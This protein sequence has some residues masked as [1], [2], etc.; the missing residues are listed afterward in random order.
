MRAP[1]PPRAALRGRLRPAQPPLARPWAPGRCGA[2]SAPARLTP[3][4]SRCA[5]RRLPGAERGAVGSPSGLRSPGSRLCPAARLRAAGKAGP[6]DTGSGHGD[7][8]RRRDGDGDSPRAGPDPSPPSRRVPRS[9]RTASSRR[10][11]PPSFPTASA[12]RLG[13]LRAFDPKQRPGPAEPARN[14][15]GREKQPGWG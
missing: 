2:V 1:P 7:S 14:P 8:H 11:T 13:L 12:V 15:R 4:A 3:Q 9:P 10:R 5:A 6:G